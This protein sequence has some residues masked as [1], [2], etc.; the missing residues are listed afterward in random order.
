MEANRQPADTPRTD[1][2][3]SG[4]LQA[5][6]ERAQAPRLWAVRIGEG[7]ARAPLV[8]LLIGGVVLGAHALA[9]LAVP[10]APHPAEAGQLGTALFFA[11]SLAMVVSLAGVLPRAALR[12]LDALRGQLALADGDIARLRSALVRYPRR[13]M[14]LNAGAGAAIGVLHAW[15]GLWAG[16]DPLPLAP[17]ILPAA[18]TVILWAL[19][20]QTGVVLVA[21]ARLFSALGADAAQVEVLAVYRLRPFANAALRPMLLIMALLAAYPLML[22]GEGAISGLTLIAF[23]ATLA[24]ALFAVWLPLRGIGRRIAAARAEGLAR[25]DAA[26]SPAWEALRAGERGDPAR[27]QALLA[28]RERVKMAPTLPIGLDVL[29]RGLLYLALPAATWGAKGVAEAVLDRLFL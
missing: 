3:L 28:L 29:G 6:A 19:M 24:L 14:A 9:G 17:T 25:L 2:A 16:A 13:D 1:R 5:Q 23:A 22:L 21:N 4:A 12:D 8:G 15:L 26:I 20:M 10:G 7:R 27:L 11:L 18:L